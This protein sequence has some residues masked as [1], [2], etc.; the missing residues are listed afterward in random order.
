M[1]FIYLKKL[2]IKNC[3]N[4]FYFGVH[5]D[6]NVNGSGK[7]PYVSDATQQFLQTFIVSFI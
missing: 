1:F 2:P 6:Y 5:D 7:K 3:N 4:A